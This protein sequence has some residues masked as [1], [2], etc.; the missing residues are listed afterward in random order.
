[1]LPVFVGVRAWLAKGHTDMRNGFPGL[2]VLLQETLRKDPHTGHLFIFR[3]PRDDLIKINWPTS[4]FPVETGL[5]FHSVFGG[6]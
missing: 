5:F 1:M 6:R 2:A 4:L 3:G